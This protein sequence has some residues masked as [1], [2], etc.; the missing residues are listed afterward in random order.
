MEPNS[1]D[2]KFRTDI[3]AMAYSPDSRY[4]ALGGMNVYNE[5]DDVEDYQETQLH[6]VEA[7]S[8]EVIR[9]LYEDAE[10]PHVFPYFHNIVWT[11]DGSELFVTGGQGE[12]WRFDTTTGQQVATYKR[13]RGAAQYTALSP[14][15]RLIAATGGNGKF[16]IFDVLSGSVVAAI[17]ILRVDRPTSGDWI[18]WSPDGTYLAVGS[19]DGRM[20]IFDGTSFELVRTLEVYSG[21]DETVSSGAWSPD[22]RYLAISGARK[23]TLWEVDSGTVVRSLFGTCERIDKLNWHPNRPVIFGVMGELLMASDLTTGTVKYKVHPHDDLI[24]AALSPDG[25]WIAHNGSSFA[26]PVV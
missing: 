25:K 3:T 21:R 2:G 6:I 15:E 26:N 11:Q 4:I 17:E 13:T 14:N 9:T 5:G 23:T 16:E 22:S 19:R 24:A 1:Q 8:G 10:E 12:V 18:G 20:R 7:R